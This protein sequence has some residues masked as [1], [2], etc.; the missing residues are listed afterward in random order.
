M[1]AE[2]YTKLTDSVLAWKQRNQLGRFDPNASQNVEKELARQ[3]EVVKE[4]GIE[5]GKRCRVGGEEGRRG[6]VRFVGEVKEI[7]SGGV[8]VGVEADEPTGLFPFH[9]Y[10]PENIADEM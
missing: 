3:W 9:F 4:N 5:V 10:S 7:P 2:E 1:P 8:W 6:T